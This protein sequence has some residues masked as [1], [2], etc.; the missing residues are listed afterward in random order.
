ML[1]F[2]AEVAAPLRGRNPAR[3]D[4]INGCFCVWQ[5]AVTAQ[6]R[7]GAPFRREAATAHRRNEA[8]VVSTVGSLG[9]PGSRTLLP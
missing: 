6:R 2:A 4:W 5:V 1:T 7:G 9:D 8:P 3:R